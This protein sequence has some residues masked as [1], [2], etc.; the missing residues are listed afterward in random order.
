MNIVQLVPVKSVGGS[1]DLPFASFGLEDGGRI[2]FGRL[3][4]VL[5]TAGRLRESRRGGHSMMRVTRRASLLVAFYLLTSAA[6]AYAE[7]AW[8]V[9]GNVTGPPTYETSTF[10]V[11]AYDTKQACE[12]ALARQVAQV[13]R[14]KSKDTEVTVDDI[15]GTKRVLA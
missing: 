7:C 8:V 2:W 12:E 4:G 14:L 11:S 5:S 9:W 3:P 15:S 1:S 13:S 6:T 10:P